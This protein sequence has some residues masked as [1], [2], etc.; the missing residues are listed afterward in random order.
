MNCIN[1]ILSEWY[2]A[3]MNQDIVIGMLFLGA[4]GYLV[5]VFWNRSRKPSHNCGEGCNTCSAID[6]INNIKTPLP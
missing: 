1:L 2:K 4:L 5:N 6:E 3:Y